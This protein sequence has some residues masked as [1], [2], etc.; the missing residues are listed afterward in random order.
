MGRALCLAYG[1]GTACWAVR[2]ARLGS[3]CPLCRAARGPRRTP[4]GAREVA[5]V[6]AARPGGWSRSATR[7]PQ[8]LEL[9]R[10]AL[11]LELE[12][13]R[14]ALAADGWRHAR[15]SAVPRAL[16]VLHRGLTAPR[17]RETMREGQ[18]PKG[19]EGVGRMRLRRCSAR[20]ERGGEGESESVPSREGKRAVV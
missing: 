8:R 14:R 18:R 20:A 17:V 1:P 11:T 10:R 5:A 13:L 9:L 16:E 7:S 15:C 4:P 6:V 3:G 2:P 12:L 19:L